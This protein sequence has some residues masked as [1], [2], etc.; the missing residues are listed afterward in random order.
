MWHM[1][2]LCQSP[3][4]AWLAFMLLAANGCAS[5][6]TEPASH[7]EVDGTIEFNV[8]SEGRRVSQVQSILDAGGDVDVLLDGGYTPLTLAVELG[9]EA[10]VARILAAGADANRTDSRGAVPLVVAI[11]SESDEIVE[12]LIAEG[13]DVNIRGPQLMTPLHHA[14]ASGRTHMIARSLS[15]GAHPNA[16]SALGTVPLDYVQSV[17][18]ARLLIDAGACP[19]GDSAMLPPVHSVAGHSL[20]LVQ[21]LLERGADPFRPDGNGR[22]APDQLTNKRV[23]KWLLHSVEWWKESEE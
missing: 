16:H 10:L 11:A 5:H 4:L 22:I 23:K 9:D 13:A 7:S 2:P 6:S 8:D 21:F 12:L 1:R 14:A 3:F 15:L 19:D 18:N 17:A 20:E